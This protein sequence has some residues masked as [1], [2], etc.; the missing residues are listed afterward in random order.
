MVVSIAWAALRRRSFSVFCTLFLVV[1]SATLARA[2][3]ILALGLWVV[4]SLL[5]LELWLLFER[6]LL[7]RLGCRAP[8]R[9]EQP[10]FAAA[11]NRFAIVVRVVDDPAPWVASAVRTVLV[12]RGALDLIEDRGLIGVLGH[13]AIQQRD[14]WLVGAW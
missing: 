7:E 6:A 10:H 4:G 14:A 9:D 1:V 11:Q 13:A 3:V 8:T 5:A 2:S 12:S